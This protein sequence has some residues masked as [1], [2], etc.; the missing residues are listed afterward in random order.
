MVGNVPGVRL[1]VVGIVAVVLVGMVGNVPV[2]RV[3]MV[4][5]VLVSVVLVAG[6]WCQLRRLH[7]AGN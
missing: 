2:V 6:R 1:R 4:D 7:V 3:G 5:V